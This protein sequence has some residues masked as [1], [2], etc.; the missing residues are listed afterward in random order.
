MLLDVHFTARHTHILSQHG[1]GAAAAVG[2]LL[3]LLL[4]MFVASPVFHGSCRAACMPHRQHGAVGTSSGY[5]PCYVP[6]AL[7]AHYVQTSSR[8]PVLALNAGAPDSVKL[9][10]G[11]L[12]SVRAVT[13][14]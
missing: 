13:M 3:P 8:V 4:L 6:G 7:N 14:H 1:A 9:L 2:L 11:P 12:D 5:V 10:C